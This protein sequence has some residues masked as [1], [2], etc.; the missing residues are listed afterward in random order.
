LLLSAAIIH[1]W[2]G[3]FPRSP[4]ASSAFMFVVAALALTHAWA[5]QRNSTTAAVTALCAWVGVG[6]VAGPSSSN[7]NPIWFPVLG[8]GAIILF[9]ALIGTLVH[10][11]TQDSE[12]RRQVPRANVSPNGGER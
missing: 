6:I 7:E 2:L 10:Q 9:C 5:I 12:P 8:V 3:F 11:W 1:A 4:R